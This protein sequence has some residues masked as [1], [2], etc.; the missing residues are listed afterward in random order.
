MTP[1]SRNFFAIRAHVLARSKFT[2]LRLRSTTIPLILDRSDISGGER[3]RKTR[4]LGGSRDVRARARESVAQRN[5][6]IIKLGIHE[7]ASFFTH[8]RNLHGYW[9]ESSTFSN[10]FQ[11]WK[12]WKKV[13]SRNLATMC[14]SLLVWNL[15]IIMQ[16]CNQNAEWNIGLTNPCGWNRFTSIS[17][18]RARVVVSKATATDRVNKHVKAIDART[19]R[20]RSSIEHPECPDS[21]HLHIVNCV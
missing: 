16:T 15:R 1:E 4:Y 12:N 5:V 13:S 10:F 17:L 2:I 11:Y 14:S 21:L 8:L 7:W 20:L 18:A 3:E 9:V 6:T 19:R